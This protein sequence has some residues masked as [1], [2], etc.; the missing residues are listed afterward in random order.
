MFIGVIREEGGTHGQ[1]EKQVAAPTTSDSGRR[2]WGWRLLLARAGWAGAGAFGIVAVLL[3]DFEAAGVAVAFLASTLLLR[4]RYGRLGAVGIALVSLVT[5]Y[6]MGAAALT[7]ARAGSEHRIGGGHCV[8]GVGG[9][10]ECVVPTRG[11]FGLRQCRPMD[12]DRAVPEQYGSVTVSL[13]VTSCSEAIEFY[14]S[15]FGAEEAMPPMLGPD[16]RIAHADC[17]G[18]LFRSARRHRCRFMP[19]LR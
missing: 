15:V 1:L 7:N 4:F 3:G 19:S 2:P 14:K 5:T 9:G 12:H 11:R 6:F 16:G 17:S 13:I 10:G 18:N 8:C